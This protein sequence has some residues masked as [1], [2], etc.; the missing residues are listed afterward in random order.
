I[1]AIESDKKITVAA[2]IAHPGLCS[3]LRRMPR[4]GVEQQKKLVEL[5][6]NVEGLILPNMHV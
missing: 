5:C 1:Y 3:S 6:S 2:Q 4:G